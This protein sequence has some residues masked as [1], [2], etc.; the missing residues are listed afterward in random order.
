MSAGREPGIWFPAIRAGTGTDVFTE[1]LVDRLQRCGMRAG[2]TWLPLRAEY[3]PW[4]V[5]AP[6]APDWA[7]LA[8]VNTWLHPRFIPR[9]MPVVATIHHSIHD[10]ALRPY[11]GFARGLYHARWIAPIERR[12]MRR[13]DAIVA[14][15]RFVAESARRHLLDVPIRV[16]HNGV[17][18][19]RFTPPQ[20]RKPRDPF[21]LL[22]VGTWSERKGAS[23]LAPIMRELGSGYELHY[24]GNRPGGT[25]ALPTNMRGVGRLD[26]VGVIR[27]MREAAALLFPSRSEG[28]ALVVMEAMAC[29]LPVIA[30]ATSVFPEMIED[31]ASGL[32]V[33]EDSPA[34]FAEAIRK[35]R[36]DPGLCARMS[37]AARARAEQNFSF[38]QMLDAYV[39]MYRHVSE[40]R[41][42]R[43]SA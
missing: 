35:L 13:A 10:P 29:G 28:L 15:S 5:A 22:Y 26:E 7:T 38:E 30:R 11:K 24:S 8:H 39:R 18:V 31:G 27:A 1:R 36:G 19:D 23:L 2:I 12:V 16:I 6:E 25:S 20:S 40:V 41:G 3:A 32:L 42:G 43:D 21:R 4:S 37:V 33:E 17:D 34:C 14:V 9:G